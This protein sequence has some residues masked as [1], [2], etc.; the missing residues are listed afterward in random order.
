[1]SLTQ[2]VMV[3]NVDIDPEI[4]NDWDDWY[5][6]IHLPEIVA[7][8][9]FIRSTRFKAPNVDETGRLQQVTI[10]ELDRPDAM[11][12]AEFAAVRGVGPFGAQANAKARLVKQHIVYEKGGRHD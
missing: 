5:D 2:W 4:E 11:E 8:P 9:G 10:Y 6:T 3:V 1:M 12:T 7:C